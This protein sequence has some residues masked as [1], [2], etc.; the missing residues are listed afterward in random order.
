MYFRQAGALAGLTA[1]L[2]AAGCGGNAQP[3]ATS[4][5][6]V[7]A[8]VTHE[9]V[10]QSSL[11][12]A[13]PS[14][15]Q[16]SAHG[17]VTIDDTAPSGNGNFQFSGQSANAQ[18]DV[19]YCYVPVSD[20]TCHVMLTATTDAS[21]N[22]SGSFVIPTSQPTLDGRP[23]ET[24][25]VA[26]AFSGTQTL[27]TAWTPTDSTAVYSVP[28]YKTVAQGND[29][30]TSGRASVNGNNIHVQIRSAIPNTSYTASLVQQLG[31]PSGNTLGSLTTDGSGNADADFAIT[32][33]GFGVHLTPGIGGDLVD[34]VR[35]R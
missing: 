31:G 1:L 14:P 9:A 7:S 23:Y 32:A 28:L 29:P 11:I 35:T 34:G 8:T 33:P 18:Y 26:I 24:V 21:G 25:V 6:V 19:Q 30:L 20:S 17:Q 12:D 22:G 13:S 16:R 2:F 10:W 27:I 15:A 5:R 4:A 3:A